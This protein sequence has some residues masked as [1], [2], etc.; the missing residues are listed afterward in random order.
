VTP[1][2][3]APPEHEAVRILVVCWANSARSI[4]AEALFR[5]LG[6]DRIEVHSAGIEPAAEAHPLALRVLRDAGLPTDGLHPKPISGFLGQTFDYVITVCDDSRGVCPTFP[7]VQE[8][9]HWGYADPVKVEGT[10]DQRLAA[11]RAVF[12]GLGTR[13]HQFL[14]IADRFAASRSAVELA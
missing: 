8:S 12:T 4:L 13:I 7:G 11:F 1:A 3:D 9:L 2:G 6:G 5:H 10:E 14:P